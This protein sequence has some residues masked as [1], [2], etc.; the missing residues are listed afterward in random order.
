MVST[1]SSGHS[2]NPSIAMDGSGNVHVAWNDATD[3]GGSGM[4]SDVFYKRWN[5]TAGSWTVTEVVST[6]STGTSQYP[7]ITVDGS[8]NAHVAWQD[9]T[10]YSG[11]GTD[12]DIFYK[13]WDATAG[14]WTVTEVISTESTLDSYY[15]WI[16]VDGSGNVHVA[17]HDFLI[18][19]IDIFYK[20]WNATTGSWMAT[21][22]VSTESTGD[23]RSPSIAVD[24]SGNVHVAW[25]DY[26][27]YNGSGTDQ[28]IFY[29]RWNATAVN[30]TATE[31]VST[32]STGGSSFPSIA[33]DGSGNVHVAWQDW[34]NYSG[35]GTDQD[36]FYKRWDFTAGSWTVTEVVSIE[37]MGDSYAPSIAVDGP[38]NVH[39]AW[40]DYT[41]YSG[42][43]T[44][45]DVFYKCWNTTAGSWMA[46]EVVSTES[47]GDCSIPSIAVDGPGKVHVAWSDPTNYSGSGAD[48][49]IFY[50]K[51]TYVPDPPVLQSITPDPDYDGII[52]LYWNDVPNATVYH[53]FRDTSVI[54]STSGLTPIATVPDSN[55]TDT[56]TINATTYY[57]VIVAGNASGNSPISNCENVTVNIPD[58]LPVAN[59][60]A[61]QTTVVEGDWVQ[62]NYTGTHGN[63]I[64]SYE[65]DFG[66]GSPNSTL[67]DPDHKFTTDGNFTVKLL[68]IDVD[69]DNSTYNINITVV[70]LPPVANFTAGKKTVIEGELIQFNYTGT[71]GNGI[72]S[73]EWDF[74]DGSPNSTDENPTH[75]YMAPGTYTVTLTVNDTDGDTSTVQKFNFIEVIDAAEGTILGLRNQEWS[76][77][78]TFVGIM[79][80]LFGG[81]I[82]KTKR[83]SRKRKIG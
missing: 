37:S 75:R 81:L 58:L 21:E 26:T 52:D 79:N 11:S 33:V 40:N 25:Y 14:S 71:R 44:D 3:Y 41:N 62:F 1:E 30:W 68:V 53:V 13:R 77:L 80:T 19:D 7:S 16:A 64:T 45:R 42:S 9:W 10:N 32:E 70:N 17:W 24:G 74:G 50:K 56:S 54:A 28:D 49:D 6:E 27:N 15:P 65:W 57:Y 4:D 51:L 73:F 43:G 60:S 66:D 36:I 39:V 23:S 18:P 48:S 61:N 63:G 67:Q 47:T 72:A 82:W 20:R 55:Y 83:L 76:L 46:T 2:F 8:G 78:G 35:S 22:V 31:V 34:T 12:Q 69:G 5:A 59:F 29:K 38:G